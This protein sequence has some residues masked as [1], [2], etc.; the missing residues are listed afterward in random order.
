MFDFEWFDGDIGI[1]DWMVIGPLA[2]ELAEEEKERRRLEDELDQDNDQ[3][4]GGDSGLF[5]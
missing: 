3:K 1:E 4:Q 2:E 5:S